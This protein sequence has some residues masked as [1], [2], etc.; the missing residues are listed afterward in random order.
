MGFCTSSGILNN[1][2]TR[3]YRNWISFR[4]QVK[5]EKHTLLGRLERDDLS[6]WTT[7]VSSFWGTRQS[8]T[9]SP[10]PPPFTWGREWVQ[11]PKLCFLVFRISDDGQKPRYPVVLSFIHRRKNPVYS[12]VISL[13]YRARHWHL[14]LAVCH[15][16]YIT[17]GFTFT[18]EGGE[19]AEVLKTLLP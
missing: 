16:T 10:P 12:I 11:F 7:E 13:V 17:F 19:S 14:S 1:W 15:V 9:L 4:L 3:R 18:P 8:R 6:Y 2:R 5:R